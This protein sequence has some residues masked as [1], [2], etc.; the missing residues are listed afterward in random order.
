MGL[1]LYL[2]YIQYGIN[3]WLYVN[4][5]SYGLAMSMPNTTKA[6][7][8][9]AHLFKKYD[10]KHVLNDINFTIDA[11]K[12]VALLGEN[13]SGKSTLLKVLA[14]LIKPSSGNAW[15]NGYSIM[16]E[17]IK[18]RKSIGFVFQT[19]LL[20]KHFTVNENLLF[21]AALFGLSSKVAQE[22]IKKVL[23]I[24]HL[25][26]FLNKPVK[27][28]SGG[29]QRTI[30]IARSLLHHPAILLLDEPTSGLD[31]AHRTQLFEHLHLLQQQENV[32]ILFSTHHEQETT[33]VDAV[34]T[35]KAGH[36]APCI[37]QP[38]H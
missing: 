2:I 8:S 22:R 37:T 1:L 13:G 25:Y 9:V 11:G 24:F 23:S 14:T 27:L 31:D 28:L 15:V 38:S 35:V 10:H 5:R 17:P 12:S 19:P 6:A 32:T 29:T 3:S 34:Y 16:D 21:A 36:L 18:V 33:Q 4:T 30:D 26:D 20:D 7:I